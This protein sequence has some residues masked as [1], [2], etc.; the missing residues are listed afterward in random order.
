MAAELVETERIFARRVAAIDPRWAEELGAHLVKRSYG[1]PRWDARAARGL[2]EAYY[3][4]L[5]PLL[6]SLMSR[7]PEE[8]QWRE[9]LG[10]FYFNQGDMERAWD[11]FAGLSGGHVARLHPGVSIFAAEA[12][13]RVGQTERAIG[14]LRRA[15]SVH[16]PHPVLFAPA[17]TRTSAAANPSGSR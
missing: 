7:F 1:E 17:P 4:V 11:A 9:R 13:R 16:P 5:G 6:S 14:I 12:A 10:T 3:P 8:P 15:R 2:E